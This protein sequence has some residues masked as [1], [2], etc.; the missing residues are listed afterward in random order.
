MNNKVR[1]LIFLLLLAA[2]IT[3]AHAQDD[4]TPGIIQSSKLGWFYSLKAGFNIGGTAP[5]P[6]PQEIRRIESFSPGMAIAIE[7]NATKWFATSRHWGISIG[8]RLENKNMTTQAIVKNYGMKLINADSG[9][10]LE[11][12]W[13]GGVKTKV[14]GSYLTV[15]V[16][17]NYKIS[18]RWK[19]LVGPYLSYLL[20]GDFSGHVYE[21]HLRTPDP[22][23]ARVDFSGTSIATYDFSS[24]LRRLLWGVQLGGEWQAFRHLSVHADLTWG[25]NDIFQSDFQTIAFAM[26]P[27]YL[28][29]G[30]GYSF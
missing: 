30:F 23:G 19:I 4:N 10:Y 28:N 8:L 15:P 21:G 16:L 20:E 25:L 14:K 6:I 13:T 11:G 7:G 1:H 3:T 27:I 26:Y 12:L 22:T 18:Q 9:S 2:G 29:L 5:L 17:A 24:D